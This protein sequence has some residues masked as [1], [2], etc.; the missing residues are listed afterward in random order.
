MAVAGR[1]TSSYA[2]VVAAFASLGSAVR[3]NPEYV[4]TSLNHHHIH[5]VMG[6][7]HSERP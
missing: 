1:Q 6:L 4:S 5:T 3:L 7:L 2:R